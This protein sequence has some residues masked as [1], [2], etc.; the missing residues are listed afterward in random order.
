MSSNVIA[1]KISQLDAA[2]CRCFPNG[3]GRGLELVMVQFCST[4]ETNGE[5]DFAG[6]MGEQPHF[7]NYYRVLESG[8]LVSSLALPVKSCY[9]F[10]SSVC[11]TGAGNGAR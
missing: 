3:F 11:T 6:V 10:D 8:G 2:V 7:Q 1:T 5:C 4:W 9:S